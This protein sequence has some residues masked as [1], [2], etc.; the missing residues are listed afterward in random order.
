[1]KEECGLL[2]SRERAIQL[3]QEFARKCQLPI[4]DPDIVNF[5]VA[6][7]SS[8]ERDTWTIVFEDATLPGSGGIVIQVIVPTQEVILRKV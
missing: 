6:K 7:L 5:R 1:M 2:M 4:G 8:T 3:A